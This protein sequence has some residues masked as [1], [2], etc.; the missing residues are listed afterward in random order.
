MRQDRFYCPDF[1]ENQITDEDIV[2][3]IS[4]V[5]RKRKGD[6]VLIFDGKGKEYSAEI[7]DIGK[8]SVTLNNVKLE[9]DELAFKIEISIA[10]PAIKPSNFDYL[11]QKCTESGADVFIPFTSQYSNIKE[12]REMKKK[13][14]LSVIEEACAQSRRNFLP[15]LD[16]FIDFKQ[17]IA[18]SSEYDLIVLGE[19]YIGNYF[20][21]FKEKLVA[22]KSK[23]KKILLIIGPEGGLSDE[24]IAKIK[25]LNNVYLLKF[26][27]F[28]FRAETAASYLCALISMFLGKNT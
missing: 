6:E 3:K 17:L 15:K 23:I 5:L 26:S 9:C 11:L 28:I 16:E 8:K 19:P 21:N 12:P 27:N 1:S 13:H 25:A 22:D 14:F 4:K 10:A 18:K 7:F 20:D 24:E 2:F